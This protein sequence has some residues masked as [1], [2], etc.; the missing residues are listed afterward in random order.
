MQKSTMQRSQH[1]AL[2]NEDATMGQSVAMSVQD[3][4]ELDYFEG[5]LEAIAATIEV[6]LMTRRL[7]NHLDDPMEELLEVYQDVKEIEANLG[8]A[9]NIGSKCMC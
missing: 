8:K 6:P 3:K 1:P 2:G 9:L 4:E 5:E 7:E